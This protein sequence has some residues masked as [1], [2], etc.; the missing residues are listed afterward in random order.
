MNISL[1]LATLL[2][3]HVIGDFYLQ[4]NN[5]VKK[6]NASYKWFFAHG[7][8]YATCIV[9]ALLSLAWFGGV[10]Y[11]WNLLWMFI[12]LSCSHLTIDFLKKFIPS[13]KWL[14]SIDQAAHFACILLA[15]CMWGRG[16]TVGYYIYEYA[17]YLNI[18]LGLLIILRP[19][20]I[21]LESGVIWD[22]NKKKVAQKD[23]KNKEE[24]K[25]QEEQKDAGRI[26]GY[27]E[28]IVVYFLL[29]S[30]EYSA[31]GLVISAKS[32]A[33]FPEIKDKKSNLKANTYI[34]G[35]FLSLTAVVAVAVLLGL[36]H[37]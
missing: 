34:I 14:F 20:G 22:F 30:G 24:K 16:L 35:T 10:A 6:K 21:L 25:E 1:T 15:W 18:P 29:L 12:L 7:I 9:L 36:V 27:L 28:R 37:S 4:T 11:S 26:I 32:I 17:G 3:G 5:M 23:D 19:V 13:Q 8:V 31:I 33:R 2:L